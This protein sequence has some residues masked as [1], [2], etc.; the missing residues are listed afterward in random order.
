MEVIF[1]F[2]LKLFLR[3]YVCFIK[4]F[5]SKP[6][7]GGEQLTIEFKNQLINDIGTK[8]EHF[9][10]ENDRTKTNFSVSVV[11][12]IKVPNYLTLH[13]KFVSPLDFGKGE[14]ECVGR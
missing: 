11:I 6:K 3:F 4:K 13:C 8:Y 10:Q 12:Y 5:N 14:I 2:C 7:L 9:M 1:N